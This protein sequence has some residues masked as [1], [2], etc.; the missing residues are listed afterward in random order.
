MVKMATISPPINNPT[1]IKFEDLNNTTNPY[2]VET[3]DN[4]G[5]LLVI[6]PLTIENYRNWSCAIQR[7]LQAKNKLRFI[8]G[9]LSKPSSS[10]DPLFNL[11]ER[12]NNMLVSW[13]QNS[14]TLPLRPSVAFVDDAQKL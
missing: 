3:S 2:R 10:D 7:A 4:P 13:L 12:C 14:I 5:I 8:N 11:C 1:T 9:T 6:E